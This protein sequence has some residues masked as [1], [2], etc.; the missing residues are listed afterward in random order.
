MKQKRIGRR[1]ERLPNVVPVADMEDEPDLVSL[2]RRIVQKEVHRVIDQKREPTLYYD[3]CPQTQLLEE[4]VQ[5]KVEKALA[6]VSVNPAETQ[7]LPTCAAVTRR[8]RVLA[9]RLPTQP[10]KTD[11]WRTTDN[12]PVCFNC[13]RPGHVVRYCRERKAIFD[14]YRNR[15]Q[16]FDKIE[17]EEG[18]RRPNFLPRSTPS[19]TRGRSPTRRYRLPSPYRQPS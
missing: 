14:T 11:L 3:T 8:T 12:G 10:R 4:M 5:D 16:S 17:A 18:A 6:L 9:Q 19:P 13:G 1:F 2:I 7:R 15:R